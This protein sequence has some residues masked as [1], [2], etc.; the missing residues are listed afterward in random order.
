MSGVKKVRV[1]NTGQVVHQPGVEVSC[2]GDRGKTS[3]S[4]PD[5]GEL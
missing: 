4:G 5:F 3:R 2:S 1:V